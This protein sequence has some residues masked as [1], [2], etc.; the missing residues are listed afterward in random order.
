MIKRLIPILVLLIVNNSCQYFE[1]CDGPRY[2]IKKKI[3]MG[4]GICSYRAQS[5]GS[6]L[7]WNDQKFLDFNDSCNAYTLS[8][9]RDRKEFYLKYGI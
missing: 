9:I 8:E 5:I 2:Q 4:N 6:C 1:E 7:I 3:M